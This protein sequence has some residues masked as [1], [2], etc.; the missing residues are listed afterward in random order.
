MMV[1]LR[2]S[3][4]IA[5]CFLALPGCESVPPLTELY[6]EWHGECIDR[7]HARVKNALSGVTLSTD[8]AQLLSQ[9]IYHLPPEE[10]Q[11][12]ALAAAS[13]TNKLGH[14]P[15]STDLVSLRAI[16]HR[17][18][19]DGFSGSSICDMPSG[20]AF[21]TAEYFMDALN[22]YLFQEGVI[23]D[24]TFPVDG[25]P[26]VGRD[27]ARELMAWLII[28]ISQPPPNNSSKPTPLRGA[29]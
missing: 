13:A 1:T 24:Q 21:L 10:R 16:V 15:T 8:T 29:A 3:A 4:L 2:K 22:V 17:S 12:I 9:L 5:F 11:A 14:R 23:S 7:S 18:F 6:P 28:T 26:T 27:S 25:S 20:S 19:F